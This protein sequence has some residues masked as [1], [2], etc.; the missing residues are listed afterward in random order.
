[1]SFSLNS[2]YKEAGLSKQAVA[3]YDTRQKI[4][5]NKTAQLVLE[6]DELREYHSGYGMDRM[7]YT[8]KPDFM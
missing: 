8:L 3:Q 5:D 6:A 4:F 2:L 7:Y 1:M